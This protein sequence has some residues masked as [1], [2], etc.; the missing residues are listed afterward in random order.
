MLGLV[1]LKEKEKEPLTIQGFKP[2]TESHYP[3]R[4]RARIVLL[5][6]IALVYERL[7]RGSQGGAFLV[8][9]CNPLSSEGY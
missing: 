4:W 1:I 6:G 9:F 5:A 8:K 7:A 3:I 2:L